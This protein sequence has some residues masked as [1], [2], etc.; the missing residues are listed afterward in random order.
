MRRL[1]K[2]LM[3]LCLWPVWAWQRIKSWW[4]WLN[5]FEDD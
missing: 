3:L 5:E 4:D 1:W 2:I